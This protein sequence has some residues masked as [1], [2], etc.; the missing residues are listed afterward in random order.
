MSLLMLRKR[1]KGLGTIII[2]IFKKVLLIYDPTCLLINKATIMKDYL[3]MMGKF[4]NAL[5]TIIR[6]QH[7]CQAQ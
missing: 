3:R 1:E 2:A 4:A 6:A 5:F 7:I